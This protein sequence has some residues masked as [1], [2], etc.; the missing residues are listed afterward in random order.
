[1]VELEPN[2]RRQQ[3]AA[4]ATNQ[5]VAAAAINQCAAVAAAVGRHLDMCG[6]LQELAPYLRPAGE[7]QYDG[8]YFV[9][10]IIARAVVLGA[11]G[12]ATVC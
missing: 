11:G 7:Q 2:R 10:A 4:V 3:P 8:V 9:T 12:A 1:M 6:H 5:C